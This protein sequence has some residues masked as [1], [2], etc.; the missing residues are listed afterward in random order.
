MNGL[1][2]VIG[3][4]LCAAAMGTATLAYAVDGVIL[5][6]QNRAL[7]GNVTSGDSAG[8]PITISQPGSYRLTSN[9]TVPNASTTAI[10][11]TADNV[12]IDLNGFSILGPTV[13]NTDNTSPVT[14][15]SNLGT[16]IGID[17]L[18]QVQVKNLRVANGTINGMGAEGI[19]AG[20]GCRIERMNISSNGADGAGCLSGIISEVIIRAN[21]GSGISSYSI[22]VSNSHILSNRGFGVNL[23]AIFTNQLGGM[24]IN[25]VV[26]YNGGNGVNRIAGS[27]YENNIFFGNGTLVG[28]D[29]V[30]GHT[31]PGANTCKTIPC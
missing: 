24:L 14:A 19:Q 23:Q 25:S 7:A 21:Y 30:T 3:F 4:A 17:G 20:Q 9:L 12:S 29:E 2:R 11:V 26:G 13:C 15:C 18:S 16:G 10:L 6:D 8:F 22:L 5:I 31:D 27:R 28:G 1:K